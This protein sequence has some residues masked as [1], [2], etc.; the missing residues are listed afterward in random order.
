[1]EGKTGMKKILFVINTMG[2]AGAE[3]ALIEL[4]KKLNGPGWDISLYVI[5]GQGEMIS[6][7]PGGVRLLNTQFCDQSVLSKEGRRNCNI[8]IFPQWESPE[9][10]RLSMA[11]ISGHAKKRKT[12]DR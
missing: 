7:L 12:T 6:Q 11:D 10:N 9:K 8:C 1:M 4:L 5:M 2:R 3:T